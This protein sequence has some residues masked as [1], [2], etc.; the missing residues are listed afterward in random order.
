MKRGSP[1]V[2]MLEMVVD[3]PSTGNQSWAGPK[4]KKKGKAAGDLAVL[5]EASRGPMASRKGGTEKGARAG[6]T[7]RLGEEELPTKQG[8]VPER[9]HW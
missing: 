6:R 1:K 2:R 7:P 5:S 4:R 8:K 3:G 9:G